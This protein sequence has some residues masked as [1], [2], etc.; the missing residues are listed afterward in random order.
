ML[1]ERNTIKCI[2]H[3][4]LVIIMISNIVGATRSYATAFSMQRSCALKKQKVI[5][6]SLAADTQNNVE[7][8]TEDEQ[9]VPLYLAEGLFAVYKPLEW[10][11]N[12][13]VGYIRK[14]LET[15]ARKRGATVNKRKS[16]KGF[17]VGHGGTLD[18]LATG[19]IVLGVGSGTKELQNYLTGSKKYRAS[20]ELGYETNTLDLEGNVTITA[21][22][23]HITEDRIEKVIP[24]FVGKIMQIPPIFSAIRKDGKRLYDEARAGKTVDDI[25][26]EPREVHIYGLEYIKHDHN[27]K[28]L[29]CFGLNVECGGGTYIR[30]LVRDIGKSLDSVA[31]MT[32]LERTQQGVFTIM[33]AIPKE[34]WTVESI[35]NAIERA[36]K[37]RSVTE[38]QKLNEPSNQMDEKT[39]E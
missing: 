12:D 23:D 8:S 21:P 24:N 17:K 19:V 28:Q 1:D 35:Y 16:K 34:E 18:P 22:F 20:V 7:R 9:V 27:G 10:T 5:L 29:P 6:S 31:T 38:D 37:A 32:S 25:E 33:D 3:I 39:I 36:N 15:D 14:M 4:L 2:I 11:S 26:I 30:S 13:V